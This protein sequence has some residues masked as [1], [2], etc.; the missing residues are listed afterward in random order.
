M[1]LKALPG[2]WLGV[3]FCLLYSGCVSMS[4]LQSPKVLER[5]ESKH[6]IAGTLF[7]ENGVSGMT[8]FDIWGYYGLGKRTQA[9]WKFFGIPNLSGGIGADL[10]YQLHDAAPYLA[11][12]LGFSYTSTR[13]IFDEDANNVDAFTINPALLFG[14]ERLYGGMKG[15]Y[16][17]STVEYELFGK[18][19]KITLDGFTPGLLIG[20]TLGGRTQLVTELN[21]YSVR[22]SLAAWISFGFQIK[23]P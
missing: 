10:K 7:V 12:D 8:E 13:N 1:S 11:L 21:A 2:T 20:S 9:G 19:S 16:L 4:T 23:S 15:I 22:G 5:G 3:A 6:G 18:S 14:T 17:S